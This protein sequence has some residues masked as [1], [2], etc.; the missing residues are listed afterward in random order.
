MEGVKI[1]AE[2][3]AERSLLRAYQ[4]GAFSGLA[5]HGK[6]KR[7]SSYSGR[8]DEPQKPGEMLAALKTMGVGSSMK[9]KRVRLDRRAEA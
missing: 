6:L 2:A 9:I 5:H 3:D 1:K 4:S 7:F 8:S